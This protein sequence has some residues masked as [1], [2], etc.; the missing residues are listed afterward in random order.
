MT[1]MELFD[2]SPQDSFSEDGIWNEVAHNSEPQ[3]D[4]SCES[5]RALG[6]VGDYGETPATSLQTPR[7]PNHPMVA[8]L[9]CARV[10]GVLD[11]S[12]QAFSQGAS[13]PQAAQITQELPAQPHRT[14]PAPAVAVEGGTEALP[15]GCSPKPTINDWRNYLTTAHWNQLELAISHGSER[16]IATSDLYKLATLAAVARAVRAGMGLPRMMDE[17]SKVETYKPQG[18]IVAELTPPSSPSREVVSEEVSL[19]PVSEESRCQPINFLESTDYGGA[20]TP[21]LE[22]PASQAS[23]ADL[24]TRKGSPGVTDT[25]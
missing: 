8:S 4:L 6:D 3:L 11:H 21:R 14:S 12:V 16:D 13:Q 5:K 20:S 23:K 2:I 1:A 17:G 9:S 25:E 15:I 18:R 24:S 7:S 19:D 10:Q 22:A